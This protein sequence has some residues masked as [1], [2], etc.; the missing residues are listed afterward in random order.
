[1]PSALSLRLAIG[2]DGIG[3]ELAT[4]AFLECV[5]VEE[6]TTA[7]PG[8]RF[9]VDVSGGVARF[10]HRRGALQTLRLVVMARALERW[11]AP[12]LR[13]IV[14][15][16]TPDV[17][18]RVGP[19]RATVCVAAPPEA[20]PEYERPVARSPETVSTVPAV[21]AFDVLAVAAGDDLQFVVTSARGAGL[22]APPTALALACVGAAFGRTAER[23][24]VLF[25]IRRPAE[26]A[27]R[28]LFPEAGARVPATDGVCWSALSVD[29]DAWVLTA[30]HGATAAEPAPDA[31]RAREIALLL[32]AADDALLRGDPG[33]ARAGYLAALEHAPRHPEIAR[34]IADVDARAPGRAEA[35]LAALAEAAQRETISPVEASLVEA[36]LLVR[37]GDVDAAIARLERGGT[38]EPA[39]I[40]AARSFEM[41]A[42]LAVDPEARVTWL[43]RAL[44]RSP[45][46]AS[47]RWARVQS[48]LA[49]GRLEEGLADVEFLEAIARGRAAKCAV[50]LRAG[51]AWQA[52]GLGERAG[53]IFERALRY[54]PDD[55]IA[56]MGL[57][58][59]LAATGRAARGVALLERALAVA[60]A[61]RED[62]YAIEVAL[63]RAL[64]EHL[65]DLHAAIAHASA[66]PSD[67]PEGGIAR[68]LEGRWRTRVGDTTG[69]ALAFARLRDLA[70]SRAA[71]GLGA[72]VV[73]DLG[74]LLMEAARFETDVRRDP[75]A[76][77]R[78]LAA[79]IRLDPNDPDLRRAYRAAG[80]R[81]VGS[82]R[83]GEDHRAVERN[84]AAERPAEGL[85]PVRA[86][87]E[88]SLSGFE[89][90]PVGAARVDDLTRRLQAQPSDDVVADEL[91]R[92]LEA[93]GQGHELVALLGARLDEATPDRRPERI[94]GARRSLER[95]LT[96]AVSAG[97]DDLAALCRDALAAFAPDEP[98]PAR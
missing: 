86:D 13:G 87:V 16:S 3:L 41:A 81:I 71:T 7:L 59:A 72:G 82:S 40:L 65:D 97:R 27:V 73:T 31:V 45:R 51:Q 10:R 57:G 35:A 22:P 46:V 12:R 17:W 48:R 26:A 83:A 33:E 54:E 64:A 34:R 9:P 29:G 37:A 78:H 62:G 84:D 39:P 74:A 50:W 85:S 38:T 36:E 56:L 63:A 11:L 14:S 75:L 95:L 49:L 77:Q 53:A 70:T 2:R 1:V 43:D 18:I 8:T 44:A 79:A 55:P 96:R 91:V 69:A 98:T 47:A 58:V 88:P 60:S 80:E 4:S 66:V 92:L 21:V 89:D 30:A 93:L 15:A 23:T 76:A 90:D 25:R 42:R 24:G 19:A 28:A 68:G 94:D 32:G 20:P 5:V 52:A 6:M 67:A 61:R